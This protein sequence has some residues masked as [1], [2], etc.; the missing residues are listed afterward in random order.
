[1]PSDNA[2]K[3]PRDWWTMD[4]GLLRTLNA[5][6]KD[7]RRFHSRGGTVLDQVVQRRETFEDGAHHVSIQVL[8]LGVG[9]E[10]SAVSS[11]PH[12][13][14]ARV[15]ERLVISC[16]GTAANKE[17][18][19]AHLISLDDGGV[20]LGQQHPLLVGA[21]RAGAEARSLLMRTYAEFIFNQAAD[22]SRVEGAQDFPVELMLDVTGVKRRL[23]LAS[24]SSFGDPE[25]RPY[26][27]KAIDD[28]VVSVLKDHSVVMGSVDYDKLYIYD[29]DRLI[30]CGGKSVLRGIEAAL[31]NGER[32]AAVR[33]AYGQ[34]KSGMCLYEHEDAAIRI[35][36][37]I[38]PESGSVFV[39]SMVDD[40]MKRLFNFYLFHSKGESAAVVK[41]DWL[42][43][44]ARDLSI[45][46][47]GTEADKERGTQM[48]RYSRHADE[49]N[50]SI[51]IADLM[52]DFAHQD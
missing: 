50:A 14:V 28:L 8:P 37:R 43:L 41:D 40:L 42:V 21:P 33:A 18:L 1:M 23:G 38:F 13:D 10:Y 15:D 27:A 11:E 9:L 36:E 46:F 35:V 3:L 29:G 22:A 2:A 6:Y 26:D 51:N 44:K 20:W 4:I 32:A 34:N 48:E 5:L 49:L 17:V 7:I 30:D 25:G 52:G 47:I 45:C 39:Y 16:P 31:T 24:I 12:G 19:D